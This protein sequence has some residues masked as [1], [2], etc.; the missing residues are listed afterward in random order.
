VYFHLICGEFES[1]AD[2]MEKAIEERHFLA[3]LYLWSPLAR[4]MRG[5]A[6][7]PSLLNVMNLPASAGG[8]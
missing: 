6:R 4:P 8:V 3:A 5:G 2:W 7:W 1:A